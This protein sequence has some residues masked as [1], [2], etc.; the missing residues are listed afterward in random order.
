MYPEFKRNLI[1]SCVFLLHVPPLAAADNPQTVSTVLTQV[2]EFIGIELS[3][4]QLF[5]TDNPQ[6][7][8]RGSH[9]AL[10]TTNPS[11]LRNRDYGRIHPVRVI[12]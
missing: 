6:T 12:P 11:A 8:S 9:A 5:K 1:E 4:A 2:Q 7:A 3:F 10:L